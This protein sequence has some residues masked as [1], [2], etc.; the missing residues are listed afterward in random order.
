M[1]MPV[2]DQTLVVALQ[3]H[4]WLPDRRRRAEDGVVRTRVL[5]ERSRPT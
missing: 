1:R 2:V 5:G 4:G 3:G